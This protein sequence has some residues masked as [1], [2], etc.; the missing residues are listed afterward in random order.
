[1]VQHS[2]VALS[3]SGQAHRGHLRAMRE[4][5]IGYLEQLAQQGDFLRI[6]L[7]IGSAYFINTPDLAQEVLLKQARKFH[8][9]FTVK[10]T[11]RELFGENLFTSDGALWQR[12]RNTLQPAFHTQRLT[13]YANLMIEDT[14]ALLAQWHSQQVVD[15]PA[16][17]MDLT[18]GSTT[19]A[20]FGQDLR[21]QEVAQALIRFIE[22][23]S[24]RISRFPIPAWLPIPSNRELKRLVAIGD[25]YFSQLI[26]ERRQSGVDYGDVLSLLIQAQAAD[27]TGML[28]D[29]QIQNEV[30]N[31][32][33]AGFEVIAYTLAFTLYLIAQH[34]Q[35]EARLF[36]EIDRTLGQRQMTVADLEQLPY[37]EMV[38]K[39]SMRLLP[40][41]T[42]VSRQAIEPVSLAGYPIAKNSLIL[43]APWTLHRRSEAFPNPL[44]F[45]PERFHPD[46]KDDIPKFAYLPF[47]AGPRIC[48]GNALAM[49]QMRI[50]LALIL[51]RYRLTVAP[52]YR[53]EPIYRFNTRPRY[54][55]PMIVQA[56]A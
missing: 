21:N 5:M 25:R 32:F 38:L 55:L 27:S 20:L 43:I 41:T 51:Q 44:R 28:S 31:L 53:F 46:R 12:L 47:S 8:K 22:L 24:Q 15:I 30:S 39:E 6:P 23:F 13:G 26:A 34:P 56:R 33:A 52:D 7:G 16:A 37:L 49:M 35:V 14:Q 9:P 42:A 10:Y 48:I 54:G 17:M 19:K 1:M 36:D 50:N 18:L 3:P 11:A 29:R 2:P 45:D 4:D 40:V